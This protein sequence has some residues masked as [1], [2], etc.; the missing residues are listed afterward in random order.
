MSNQTVTFS[1][2]AIAECHKIIKRYPAGKHKSALLPILHIA[3]AV[4][5]WLLNHQ[6]Q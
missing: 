2:E 4:F 3:Q 1:E 6:S 5:Q